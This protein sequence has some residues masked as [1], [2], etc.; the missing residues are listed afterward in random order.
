[1]GF[2]NSAKIA[3]RESGMLNSVTHDLNIDPVIMLMN[4]GLFLILLVILNGIFWKP[5]MAHLE[6]RK[7]DIQ[8]AYKTVDDTRREMENLRAE[9]QGRLNHI[10]AE[11]RGQI[12]E[13]VRD[14][15]AQREQMIATARAEAEKLTRQGAASLEQEREQ[16]LA[17][18]RQTLDDVA[19]TALGKAVGS[20]ADSAQRKLVDE[21]IS[22]NVVRS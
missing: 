6:Q 22:Q 11:A 21:F 20:T 2:L 15:Q 3:C 17:G 12:Q 14:A 7:H 18:M 4:G 9:Y 5:M 13:T 19:L 10:E 16:T 1:M 8:H